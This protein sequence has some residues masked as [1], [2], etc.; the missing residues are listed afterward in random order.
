[1]SKIKIEKELSRIRD[2]LSQLKKREAELTKELKLAEDA[3]KQSILD[4]HHISAEALM[5]MIK[6]KEAE[7]KK[8]LAM[9]KE[10]GGYKPND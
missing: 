2:Q 8:L 10:Q 3:E 9:S 6:A 7:E 1:M 4:K 5:E